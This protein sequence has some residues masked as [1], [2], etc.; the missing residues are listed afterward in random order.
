MPPHST[1]GDETGGP[2]R[3]PVSDL[4]EF[5]L[6]ARIRARLPAPPD[7]ELWSGDDAAVVVL[8]GRRILFTTDILVEG[9]DFDLTY[10]DAADVA[11]KA[12][13]VNASDIAA[14]GGRPTHAVCALALPPE[15]SVDLADGLARGLAQAAGD[16]GVTTVGGDVSS[17]DRICVSV[18]ALG[19]APGPVTTRGGAA[20]GDVVAVTGTLGGAAGGLLALRGGLARGADARVDSLIGRQLRPAPRVDEG[21][22]LAR[23]GATALIDVS[24]GLAADLGHVLDAS[25]VGCVLDPDAVPVD[26]DLDALPAALPESP[27]PFELAVA[28]GE[29]YEIV[30]TISGDDLEAARAAL[31]GTAGL[32]VIGRVTE[33]DRRLGD[34][35]LEEWRKRAW[36][37][38]RPR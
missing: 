2:T 20:P 18:A 14:M 24:D 34:V 32:T 5:E 17:A 16:L 4:G 3:R 25:A 30:F 8:E 29:D 26:P 35:D 38:L 10:A 28:G 37:H 22:A 19:I 21:I 1:G 11:W 33:S 27:S 15:T 9:I 31:E 23:A 6:I 12:V 36:R 7:G 13:A